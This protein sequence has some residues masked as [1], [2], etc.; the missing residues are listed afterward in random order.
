MLLQ[1]NVHIEALEQL[2]AWGENEWADKIQEHAR[3]Y[4]EEQV[5]NTSLLE[6]LSEFY[7]PQAA[8][9]S[10]LS[11]RLVRYCHPFWQYDTNSGIQGQEGKS[12]IGV[13]DAL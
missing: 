9:K 13:E 4:F 1:A 8:R 12:I 2:E 10:K 11:Y 5:D 7:G 6:E 3:L